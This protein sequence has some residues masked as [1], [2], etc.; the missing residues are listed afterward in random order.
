MR[1]RLVTIP[2]MFDGTVAQN[3]TARFVTPCPLKITNVSV[4]SGSIPATVTVWINGG[5]PVS[6]LDGYVGTSAVVSCA[7]GVCTSYSGTTLFGAGTVRITVPVSGTVDVLCTSHTTQ[8][9][10]ANILLTALTGE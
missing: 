10:S 7:A 5:T 6:K 9:H 4:Y 8:V 1:E 3:G 2:V